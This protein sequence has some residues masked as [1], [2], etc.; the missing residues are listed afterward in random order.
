[1]S[2]E[3][4]KLTIRIPVQDALFAKQY[5]HE[6]GITVTEVI[7]RYLRQLAGYSPSADLEKI[8]GLIPADIDAEA[9]HRQHQLDKHR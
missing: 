2:N 4:T 8:T 7:D 1:M 6:H 9:I 5:A 3:T